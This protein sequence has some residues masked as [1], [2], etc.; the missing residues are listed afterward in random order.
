MKLF[1]AHEDIKLGVTDRI[2]LRAADRIIG[3]LALT[4]FDTTETAFAMRTVF[5]TDDQVERLVEFRELRRIINQAG[6]KWQAECTAQIADSSTECP[7]FIKEAMKQ[8]AKDK[9]VEVVVCNSD[10]VTETISHIADMTKRLG[11]LS[12]ARDELENSVALRT[13]LLTWQDV[14]AG[15]LV[16]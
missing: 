6:T 7:N 12:T 3:A 4:D 5:L 16:P 14:M 10:N 11:I 15:K 9:E 8:I 13:N 1:A 2:L